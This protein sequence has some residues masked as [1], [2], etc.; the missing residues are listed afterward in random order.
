LCKAVDCKEISSIAD[1]GSGGGFPGV[2]LSILY[3]DMHVTLIEVNNKKIGFLYTLIDQLKLQNTYVSEADWRTFL[4]KT[5]HDI[6]MFCARA[7]LHTDELLRA[8][9]PGCTYKDS[10]VVYWASIHW[11]PTEKEKAFI[12][13]EYAYKVG[14]KKRRLIFFKREL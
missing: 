12:H 1:V 7:S 6:D 5:D 4:R 2:P 9:K 11:E 14:A 13:H 8:L 10:Q 3:P